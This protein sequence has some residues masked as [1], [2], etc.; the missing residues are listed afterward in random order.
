M[1]RLTL[2]IVAVDDTFH[3]TTGY[4]GQF[5]FFVSKD[6]YGRNVLLAFAIIPCK[7]VRHLCWAIEC[8]MLHGL[9]LTQFPIFTDQG[10]FLAAA[11][12]FTLGEHDE[13]HQYRKSIDLS[14]HICVEHYCRSCHHPFLKELQDCKDVLCGAIL[15]LSRARDSNHFLIYYTIQFR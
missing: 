6:G 1:G 7:N 13:K 3:Q 5:F 8:A 4:N 9:D 12:A 14:I 2:P 15:K 10:N 11:A